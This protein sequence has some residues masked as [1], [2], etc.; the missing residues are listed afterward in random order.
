MKKTRIRIFSTL[1]ILLIFPY[2]V[3]AAWQKDV[4]DN[5]VFIKYTSKRHH[6]SL[7]IPQGWSITKYKSTTKLIYDYNGVSVRIQKEPNYLSFSN[8]K[9]I[10]IKSVKDSYNKVS[11]KTAKKVTI[12]SL[13]A[14]KVIY[15]SNSKPNSVTGKGLRL[16]N[17]SYFFYKKGKLLELRLWAPVGTDNADQWKMILNSFSWR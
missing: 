12:K 4:P 16:E 15:K 2:N 17:E 13:S 14:V 6:Y 1:T 10:A 7:K 11:I 8:I 3:F 9:R 5:Q